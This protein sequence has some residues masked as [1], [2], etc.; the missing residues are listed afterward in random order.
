MNNELKLQWAELA[1]DTGQAALDILGGAPVTITEKG[2]GDPKIL[3]IMLLSRSLSHFRGVFHL[4]DIGL[5]VEARILVRCCFENAF[6]IAALIADGDKF[7]N[8]MLQDEVRSRKALGELA[9]SK[10]PEL[11][12]EVEE[13]LRAQLRDF[14]KRWP[15]AQS[16]RPKS[17]AMAGLLGEGYI[18]YS[19]L[20]ADASH[21]TLTSLNRHVGR[22][23]QDGDRLIDVAPT[24]KDEEIVMTWD[25]ACNAMM[26]ACVAVNEMLGG[27][28]A[29]QR[30]GALAERYHTLTQERRKAA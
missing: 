1:D 24:P 21:P 20:S 3:A 14:K 19:Q 23:E 28:P 27:T 15:N 16:L 10:K 7:A 4:I 13:R 8:E 18:I 25:W 5:V 22:S 26:G 11:A 29:G 30:L 9:L 2:F 6:W 17:V 12:E